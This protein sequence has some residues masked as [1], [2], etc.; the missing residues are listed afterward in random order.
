MICSL[1]NPYQLLWSKNSPRCPPCMTSWSLLRLAQAHR[2]SDLVIFL[3]TTTTTTMTGPITLPLVHAHRVIMYRHTVMPLSLSSD[4]R[5]VWKCH[6]MHLR[7]L[8][9]HQSELYSS[10]TSGGKICFR[11]WCFLYNIHNFMQDSVPNVNWPFS[12]YFGQYLHDSLY[13]RLLS[14]HKDVSR[15]CL[16]S[17][18][19]TIIQSCETVP[20]I[21][22]SDFFGCR[23]HTII[24][25]WVSEVILSVIG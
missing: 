20:N 6:I 8:Q 7:L 22:I 23:S 4:H 2:Y 18:F 14:L 11:I 16:S 24:Y 3:L 19:L 5:W 9:R 25:F 15:W 1:H 10:E 12:S 13:L 17:G 21:K